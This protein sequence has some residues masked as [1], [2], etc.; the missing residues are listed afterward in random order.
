MQRQLDTVHDRGG[1]AGTIVSAFSL[2]EI[3]LAFVGS[4]GVIGDG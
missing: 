1:T 3:S 4:L 2:P